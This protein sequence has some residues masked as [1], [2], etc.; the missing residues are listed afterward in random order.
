[1]KIPTRIASVV[2]KNVTNDEV[3][4]RVGDNVVTVLK[5]ALSLGDSRRVAMLCG[6]LIGS[7]P[8]E[9]F[10]KIRELVNADE[11]A[12]QIMVNTLVYMQG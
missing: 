12:K 8:Y 6:L 9:D 1:M 5:A 4:D 11:T 7:L 10:I 2:I 3:K